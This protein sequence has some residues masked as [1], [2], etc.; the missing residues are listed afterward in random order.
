MSIVS[1]TWHI[2]LS[3]LFQQSCILLYQSYI[4]LLFLGPVDHP[5]LDHSEANRST[6][7]L[8]QTK[9]KSL[10]TNLFCL[11]LFIPT[12]VNVYVDLVV[13]GDHQ[14]GNRIYF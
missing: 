11:I 10:R 14:I 5:D 8:K 7:K 2:S 9:Q 4:I 1:I 12:L 6:T 3:T 13:F